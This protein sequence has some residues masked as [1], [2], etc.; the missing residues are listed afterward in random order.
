MKNPMAKVEFP[1]KGLRHSQMTLEALKAQITYEPSK[2]REDAE[3]FNNLS[4]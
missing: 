1:V 3:R 2:T 4:S